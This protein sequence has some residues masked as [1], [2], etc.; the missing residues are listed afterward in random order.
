MDYDDNDFESQNLHLASEG[1]TKFPPV[2]RP[3]ALPKFDFDESL[4]A[5]LRFDS[6][7]ETEVF[8][9]IES[10]E[11]N[12]WIDTFSRGGSN[13]EFSSTA[14]GSCSISRYDNVWSEA[15]SSESVEMLLKSVGQGGYIPR[16]TVIQESDS[17]DELACLAKQMDSNP[18]PDDI[19]EF[20]DNV[21]DLQPTCGTPTSFSGLKMQVGME[22]SQTAISH[23]HGGEFSTDGSSGILEPNDM[24]QNM[25]LPMSDGSPTLFTNDESNIINQREVQTVADVSDH[26]ETHDPSTL[27]VETNITGSPMQNMVDEKQGSQQTQTN[28]QNMEDSMTKEEAVVDTQCLDQ[29]AVCGAANNADKSLILTP[30]QDFLE[31]RSVVKGP[32]NGLSSFEYSTRMETVVVSDMHKE[33]RCSEDTYSRDLSHANASENVVLLEDVAMNDQSVPD[34]CISPKAQLKMILSLPDR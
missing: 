17:C 7:V 5:N 20:K 11:H 28:N 22:Q 21:I 33:V 34:A 19:N 12:Q 15:T 10:S 1:S 13:I 31:G 23:R 9:G 3:Y 29:N 27:V 8:L 16:Q 25:D 6:L 26:G 2:L 18:K 30:P 14:T 4:Q 24:F 32:E